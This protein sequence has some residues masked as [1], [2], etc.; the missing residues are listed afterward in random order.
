MQGNTRKHRERHI[1]DTKIGSHPQSNVPPGFFLK[2]KLHQRLHA[3]LSSTLHTSLWNV[4]PSSRSPNVSLLSL[5]RLR[6]HL[7]AVLKSYSGS[8]KERAIHFHGRDDCEFPKACFLPSWACEYFPQ[9]PLQPGTALTLNLNGNDV[10]LLRW[11]G[12]EWMHS[13]LDPF[14]ICWLKGEDYKDPVEG[15]ATG[16]KKTG[17]PKAWGKDTQPANLYGLWCAQGTDAMVLGHWGFRI[18]LLEELALF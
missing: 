1:N 6:A 2:K 3:I 12:W 18:C 5:F 14:P 17:P 15:G 11:S 13:L 10:S 8:L 9:A 7:L 16:R 4:P